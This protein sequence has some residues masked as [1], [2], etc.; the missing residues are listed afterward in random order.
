MAN[1]IRIT[2]GAC[3]IALA[4][5]LSA[6]ASDALTGPGT[7]RVTDRL[8]KHIYVD[9]GTPGH[10][11]GDLDFYRQ[12]LFNKGITPTA[13][14]HSDITCTNTG[15]G[16]SNC[17]ATYFLPKG[18]IMVAGVIGSRFFYELAVIGGTGLYANA[19]GTI[20]ATYLG[21]SPSKEFLLFRLVV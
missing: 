19:R 7:I 20:T 14:G 4:S 3:A 5:A 2:M 6:V 11:A 12:Q 16:S 21:G 1:W 8:V 17:T 18:K 9:N 15:T 10:S 13:I